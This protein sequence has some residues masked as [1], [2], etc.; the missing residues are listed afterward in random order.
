MSGRGFVMPDYD[1]ELT[2]KLDDAIRAR[3]TRAL[4]ALLKDHNGSRVY[5]DDKCFMRAKQ[6]MPEKVQMLRDHMVK[7]FYD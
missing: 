2:R 3:K 6:F 7:H 5:V 4:H 1:P